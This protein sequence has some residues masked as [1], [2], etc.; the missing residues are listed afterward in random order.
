MPNLIKPL[1]RPFKNFNEYYEYN[2]KFLGSYYRGKSLN[3]WKYPPCF[4]CR[5]SGTIYDPKSRPD[6]IEGNKMRPLI[7]CSACIGSGSGLG[8]LSD[9]KDDYTKVMN[10]WKIRNN[11]EKEKLRLQKNA[12]RKLTPE[13]RYALEW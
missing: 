1:K 7:P 5:G 11:S 3:K 9:W 6:V 2:S 13:E 4:H 8:K 10:N 12:L